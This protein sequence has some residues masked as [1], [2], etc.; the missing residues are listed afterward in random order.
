[1]Y[2]MYNFNSIIQI[3]LSLRSIRNYVNLIPR[4]YFQYISLNSERNKRDCNLHSTGI[5]NPQSFYCCH[6]AVYMTNKLHKILFLLSLEQLLGFSFIAVQHAFGFG[7]KVLQLNIT[8]F[9]SKISFTS[10]QYIGYFS[11]SF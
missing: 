11:K 7:K 1:M 4:Y 6:K 9:F 5:Y 8:N 2:S 3:H 10:H